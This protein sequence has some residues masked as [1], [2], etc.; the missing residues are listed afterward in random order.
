MGLYGLSWEHLG[1]NAGDPNQVG[2]PQLP[3]K[4]NPA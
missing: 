4:G 1:V 2:G 3:I